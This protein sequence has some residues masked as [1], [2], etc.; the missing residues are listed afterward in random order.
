MI[1]PVDIPTLRRHFNQVEAW[2]VG[3]GE[4]TADEAREIGLAIRAAIETGDA[5]YLAWWAD[6]FAHWSGVVETF[7]KA[8]DEIRVKGGVGERS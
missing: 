8:E 7:A 6:W 4:W 3:C 5:D 1:N 2:A